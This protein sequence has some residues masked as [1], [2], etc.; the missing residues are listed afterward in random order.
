[1]NCPCRQLYQDNVSWNK[2]FRSDAQKLDKPDEIRNDDFTLQENLS[3]QRSA[4]AEM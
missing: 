3:Q 1:M 4:V 2:G